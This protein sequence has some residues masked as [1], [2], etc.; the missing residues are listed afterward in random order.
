MCRVL[1]CEVNIVIVFVV[2]VNIME[3]LNIL[4]C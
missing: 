1:M 3:V 2:M 4:L